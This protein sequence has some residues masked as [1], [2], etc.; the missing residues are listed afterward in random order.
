MMSPPV[1]SSVPK[2][3]A[4]SPAAPAADPFTHVELTWIERRIEN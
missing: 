2:P 4:Q 3:I 1:P